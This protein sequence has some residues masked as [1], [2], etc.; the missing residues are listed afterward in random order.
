M[1][2]D[3]DEH[4]VHE[5]A[6]IAD[7]LLSEL[8]DADIGW[9]IDVYS[10]TRENYCETF[11]NAHPT[12]SQWKDGVDS[13]CNDVFST[14]SEEL[15]HIRWNQAKQEIKVVKARIKS[16]FRTDCPKLFNY[17]NLLFGPRSRL[18]LGA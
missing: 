4:G 3:E 14:V 10:L 7:G 13:S 9:E 5:Y 1:M 15:C 17:Y 6:S 11:K 12:A 16:L 2:L 8:A 18:D